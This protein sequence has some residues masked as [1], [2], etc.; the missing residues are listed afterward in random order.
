MYF[1]LLK[2]FKYTVNIKCLVLF[3]ETALSI[4]L[5]FIMLMFCS[6]NRLVL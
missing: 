6:E 4:A 1:K 3:L 5:L 2:C